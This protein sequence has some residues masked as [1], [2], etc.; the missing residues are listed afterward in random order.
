[1]RYDIDVLDGLDHNKVFQRLFGRPRDPTA[2]V[3]KPCCGPRQA[4]NLPIQYWLR[5]VREE[6]IKK[7]KLTLYPQ[8]LGDPILLE[9]EQT[10]ERR[11]DSYNKPDHSINNTTNSSF[12]LAE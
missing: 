6:R 4:S 2:D 10:E 5:V 7:W 8:A 9:Q 1:M 11:R 3:L 12:H